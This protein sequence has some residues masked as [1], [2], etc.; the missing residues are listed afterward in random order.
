[1]VLAV[2][3]YRSGHNGPDSKSG[4]G[5]PSVGSNPTASAQKDSPRKGAVLFEP[6]RWSFES[7]PQAM[8][9]AVGRGAQRRHTTASA[10][11]KKSPLA[12]DFFH[13]WGGGIIESSCRRQWGS[14]E[15]RDA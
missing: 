7:L 3:V 1:M 12:G 9:A 15:G 10:H 8:G 5:Q 11:V 14:A 4:D 6:G 2:E 13:A